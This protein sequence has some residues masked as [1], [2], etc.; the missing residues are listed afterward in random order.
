MHSLITSD[1]YESQ[2]CAFWD[3]KI[4]ANFPSLLRERSRVPYIKFNSTDY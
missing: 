2:R 3:G 1:N 4:S